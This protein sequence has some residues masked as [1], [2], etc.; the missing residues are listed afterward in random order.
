MMI[1]TNKKD[2]SGE[3]A[4]VSLTLMAWDRFKTSNLRVEPSLLGAAHTFSHQGR[5]VKVSLP[6][7]EETTDG[8]RVK[9]DHWQGRNTEGQPNPADC[10]IEYVDVSVS[11]PGTQT[12]PSAVLEQPPHAFDMISPDEQ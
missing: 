7:A 2:T 11:L 6:A 1:D 5:S 4:T 3:S 12:F 9:L 10:L 8:A